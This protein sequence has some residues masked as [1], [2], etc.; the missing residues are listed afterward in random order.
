MYIHIVVVLNIKFVFCPCN[1]VHDKKTFVE[2]QK[3]KRKVV[4]KNKFSDEKIFWSLAQMLYSL[5]YDLIF[6]KIDNEYKMHQK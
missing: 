4:R 1:A 3:V 2:M 5:K 6:N